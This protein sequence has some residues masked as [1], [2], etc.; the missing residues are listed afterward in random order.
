MASKL[1][2]CIAIFLLLTSLTACKSP[3]SGSP[4]HQEDGAPELDEK[5]LDEDHVVEYLVTWDPGRSVMVR[6]E[7][8]RGDREATVTSTWRKSSLM[9]GRSWDLEMDD[10]RVDRLHEILLRGE[11]RR[12]N[13]GD[14]T[15]DDE[16]LLRLTADDAVW[17]LAGECAGFPERTAE[18]LEQ[19][20]HPRWFSARH[21]LA[22][23]IHAESRLDARDVY[24]YYLD[25]ISIL[26]EYEPVQGDITNEQLGRAARA[27]DEKRWVDAVVDARNAL[28]ARITLYEKSLVEGLTVVPHDE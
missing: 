9:P 15:R 11:L 21:L 25:G 26:G 10:G 28:Q 27:Y 6:L 8:E 14:P 24:H 12:V 13:A 18:D 23:G 7:V 22:A 19:L 4:K 3:P 17:E 5:V 16:C 20:F 1:L 2:H